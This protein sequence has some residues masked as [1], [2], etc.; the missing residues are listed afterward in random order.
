MIKLTLTIE[1]RKPRPQQP[2]QEVRRE[3]RRSRV[4][5]GPL[6]VLGF[7]SLATL[8]TTIVT[9]DNSLLTA[10]TRGL[11]QLASRLIGVDLGT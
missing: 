3:D 8:T 11:V 2:G 9:G 4:P 6:P 5:R 1:R 10:I 7:L